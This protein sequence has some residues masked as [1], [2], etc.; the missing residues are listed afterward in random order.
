MS[1]CRHQNLVDKKNRLCCFFSL[2]KSSVSRA[3]VNVTF[4]IGLF[5]GGGRTYVHKYVRTDARTDGRRRSRD[6]QKFSDP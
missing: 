1:Q 5:V 2:S 4:D 3:S 6:N